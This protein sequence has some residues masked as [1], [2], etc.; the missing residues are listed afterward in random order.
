MKITEVSYSIAAPARK[1]D[2][3]LWLLTGGK[4]GKLFVRQ[5]IKTK[6]YHAELDNRMH[7]NCRCSSGIINIKDKS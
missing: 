4:F 7:I 5:D 3:T 1:R 2:I 6:K